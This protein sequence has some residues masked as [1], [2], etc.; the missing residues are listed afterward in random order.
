MREFKTRSAISVVV[1]WGFLSESESR[2]VCVLLW[3]QTTLNRW[4]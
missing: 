2:S 1:V 4:K 3:A